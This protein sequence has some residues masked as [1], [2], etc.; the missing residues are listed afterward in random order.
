MATLHKKWITKDKFYYP[1]IKNYAISNYWTNFDALLHK[2]YILVYDV[3]PRIVFQKSQ[4]MATLHTHVHI[5]GFTPYIPKK[6]YAKLLD[7]F[8]CP[9]A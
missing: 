9:F 5:S 2:D 6:Q 3:T 8:C 7:R 1:V 4:N